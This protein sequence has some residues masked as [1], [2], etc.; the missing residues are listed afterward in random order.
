MNH[1]IYGERLVTFAAETAAENT[2]TNT[3]DSALRVAAW[4]RRLRG[5][6]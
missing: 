2:A 4:W 1:R 5:Q 6:R 3:A